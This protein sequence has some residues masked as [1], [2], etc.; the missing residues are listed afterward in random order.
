MSPSSSSL[1]ASLLLPREHPL[2]ADVLPLNSTNQKSYFS[3]FYHNPSIDSP[4][5]L[6]K[7]EIAHLSHSYPNTT[8]IRKALVDNGCRPWR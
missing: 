3:I 1:R 2:V 6:S 8:L 4:L 5:V 7:K